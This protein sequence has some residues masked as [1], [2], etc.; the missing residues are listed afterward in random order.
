MQKAQSMN[1]SALRE[2]VLEFR[3]MKEIMSSSVSQALGA[4]AGMLAGLKK[5]GMGSRKPADL[6]P[7]RVPRYYHPCHQ[8]R[9]FMG[10]CR[11][12]ETVICQNIQCKKH[13]QY[14][15]IYLTCPKCEL[16]ICAH[17]FSK[18]LAPNIIPLALATEDQKINDSTFFVPYRYDSDVS[19]VELRNRPA[20][21]NQSRNLV[22]PN[23]PISGVVASEAFA[24]N[25]RSGNGEDEDDDDDEE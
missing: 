5:A 12:P 23:Q 15:E 18:P 9:F 14:S 16:D 6:L 8:H 10:L 11:Y 24:G 21:R 1:F 7:A 2:K 17:C 13:I 3:Q 22:V 19:F 4:T 20:A 25:R